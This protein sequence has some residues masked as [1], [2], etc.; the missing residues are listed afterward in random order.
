M[1]RAGLIPNSLKKAAAVHDATC[2]YCSTALTKDTITIDHVEGQSLKLTKDDKGQHHYIP[3]SW[4][5]SV[6][7]KVHIDRP[8]KDAMQEWKTQPS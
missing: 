7:D 4:I 6:D 2:F 5:R 1:A 8:G 3:L